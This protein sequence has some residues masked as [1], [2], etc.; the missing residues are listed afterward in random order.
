M[1]VEI[2]KISQRIDGYGALLVNE[3]ADAPD[4]T[5]DEYAKNQE[6]VNEVKVLNYLL[7][8]AESLGAKTVLDV[9]C[10]V[11]AMVN[12]FSNAGYSAYGVDLPGLTPH[13]K[14]NG[15]DSA[16]M[17][18]VD[19]E[20]LILPFADNSLDFVYTLGVI[21]HVGTTNGHSDRC[22]DYHAK[23]RDWLL[24]VYRVIKPG[25]AGLIAGP[26]RG[27][28]VDVA[29]DLDSRAS[30]LEKWL[31]Q[32]LGVSLHKTWGENFLWGYSDF[33]QYLA[34]QDYRMEAL[35]VDK[36]LS[37]GR[38]PGFLRPIVDFYIRHLPKAMR[39]TGFNPWVM[40][41]VKKP[42]TQEQTSATER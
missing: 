22:A 32:N 41:L 18:V 36:F 40:A 1:I 37:F 34:G 13:W 21:E 9:G 3:A 15:L 25:G 7:P 26:N 39:A 42:I 31:S 27:F 17:F 11:G 19:P 28:P 30:D 6:L 14:R 24:E 16:S 8:L 35:S 20:K 4:V 10:G 29:H 5:T 12:S 23:R 33:P 38:V 2:N